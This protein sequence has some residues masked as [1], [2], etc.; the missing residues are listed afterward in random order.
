MLRA[1]HEGETV[2]AHLW[3]HQ[4]EVVHSHLAAVNAR[5]YDL[6]ASY[7]MYWT[8]LESF[9][10]MARWLNFGAGAGLDNS[11]QDGLTR[12]KRGW[13]T[14]TR[15]AYFCARIFDI[16]KYES[17]CTARDVSAKTNYFP[18]YRQGEFA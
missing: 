4:G 15:T 16:Q 13:T 2:G 11:D 1:I 6:M 3:Y 18:A 10:K 14:N 7:A 12:F 9:S 5:G 8:A 17:L